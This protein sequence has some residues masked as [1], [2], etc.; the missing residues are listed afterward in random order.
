MTTNQRKRCRELAGIA[1]VFLSWLPSSSL[2]VPFII[3]P[4][5]LFRSI[6]PYSSYYPLI[7]RSLPY[8]CSQPNH[9]WEQSPRFSVTNAS[10]I[11]V[12]PHNGVG[13]GKQGGSVYD[14]W[15]SH[16]C[17]RRWRCILLER[18]GKK[19]NVPLIMVRFV[20]DLPLPEIFRNPY[21]TKEIE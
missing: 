3:S 2:P 17:H 6:S 5:C 10:F 1:N 12:G 13:I 11:H 19:T 9:C 4:F 7:S 14:C 8:V 20:A 15:R 18:Y 16:S 21:S